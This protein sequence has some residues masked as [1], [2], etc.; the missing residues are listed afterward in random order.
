MDNAHTYKKVCISFFILMFALCFMAWTFSEALAMSLRT[1]CLKHGCR[2]LHVAGVS[3]W[4]TE[5]FRWGWTFGWLSGIT[6]MGD[7]KQQPPYSHHVPALSWILELS[8]PLGP[9]GR[10]F[11]A[12][13]HRHPGTEL[14]A[15]ARAASCLVSPMGWIRKRC[16]F[17]Q[18]PWLPSVRIFS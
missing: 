12:P 2:G 5:L 1:W 16:P 4:F 8:F 17:P 7:S 11:L 15:V 18:S 3:D 14:W 10:T 9:F 6:D 13:M